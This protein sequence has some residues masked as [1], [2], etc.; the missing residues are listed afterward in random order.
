M[1]GKRKVTGL[2]KQNGSSGKMSRPSLDEKKIELS[3]T[4]ELDRSESEVPE[5]GW[6]WMVAFGMALM[7]VC[8][9]HYLL[10]LHYTL[11]IDFMIVL[12]IGN[13]N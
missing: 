10:G 8:T 4:S 5:G 6:G 11:V 12:A 2:G 13:L 9:F 1:S 7:F 3:Q